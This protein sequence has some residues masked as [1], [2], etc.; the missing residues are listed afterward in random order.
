M[1][2]MDEKLTIQDIARIT[3]LSKDTLRYYEKIGLIESVERAPNG[4][5][6]YSQD[7]VT[8]I[9]FLK[10]LRATSMPIQQMQHYACLYRQGDSTLTERRIL[11]ESRQREV[12][13]RVLEYRQ[14]LE[15]IEKKVKLY[16][17]LEE[18]Y[19]AGRDDTV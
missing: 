17:Q 3:G 15:F 16:R 7:D 10:R 6:R 11:L 8:W 12:E 14:L 4:H 5:R 2:M 13:A 1:D 19:N 18:A 9:E